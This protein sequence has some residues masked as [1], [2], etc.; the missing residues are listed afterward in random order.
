LGRNC[1]TRSFIRG[2]GIRDGRMG[3]STPDVLKDFLNL[4]EEGHDLECFK[5]PRYDEKESNDTY[6]TA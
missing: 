5:H 1:G 3:G 2:R 6:D 4:P